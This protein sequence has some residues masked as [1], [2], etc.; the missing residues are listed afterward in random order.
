MSTLNVNT[1]QNASGG[2][3]IGNVGKIIQ[4]QSYTRV[5]SYTT[6][7]SDGD[8]GPDMGLNV[9]ITPASSSNKVMVFVNCNL[10][11]TSDV[12]V[13]FVVYRDGSVIDGWRGTSGEGASRA[14]V[15]ASGRTP[16]NHHMVPVSAQYLDSPSSTSQVTYSVRGVTPNGHRFYLNRMEG[17]GGT[18]GNS[19]EWA[20]ASST[21]TAMEVAA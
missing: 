19:W 4:V 17:S 2:N 13:G 7:I 21:I 6:V 11:M 10:G 5:T 16:S 8:Y 9:N 1:L 15:S 20:I 3:S 12:R 18:P 14:R